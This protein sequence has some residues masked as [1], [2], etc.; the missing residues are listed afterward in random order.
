VSCL[1]RV[2]RHTTPAESPVSLAAFLLR[3]LRRTSIW[4]AW[5]L[6]LAVSSLSTEADVLAPT[7]SRSLSNTLAHAICPWSAK[8]HPK[9]ATA[10]SARMTGRASQPAQ[11]VMLTRGAAILPEMRDLALSHVQTAMTTLLGIVHC[12][13]LY[14]VR[15]GDTFASTLLV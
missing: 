2:A 14:N 12:A 5:Y 1:L 7:A 4:P 15:C 9:T 11:V 13:D 10:T 3:S 8:K 6:Q